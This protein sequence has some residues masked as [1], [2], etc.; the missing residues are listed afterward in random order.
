MEEVP[1]QLTLVYGDEL[2]V[3]MRIM[4]PFHNLAYHILKLERTTLFPE[5]IPPMGLPPVTT[6]TRCYYATVVGERVNES[7]WTI[8]EDVEP[9]EPFYFHVLYNSVWFSVVKPERT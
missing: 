2:E 5:D 6:R 7:P 4:S 8:V 3:G 9:L 1:F